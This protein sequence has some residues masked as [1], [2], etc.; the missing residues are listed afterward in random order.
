MCDDEAIK[1]GEFQALRQEITNRLTI[2]Y[3]ILALGLAAFGT[4]FSV[5]NR[6]S[7]VLAALSG[8]S[9]L[10]WLYWIDNSLSI[11]RIAA[12]I[13]VVLA[14]S[15]GTR[16]AD[17]LSWEM[18][19]RNVCVGGDRADLVLFK[20]SQANRTGRIRPA[21]SADWYATILF[22]GAPPVLLSLY[23]GAN[24]HH[25]SPPGLTVWA[26]AVVCA[27]IWAYAVRAF[28]RLVQERTVFR[29]A[30]LSSRPPSAHP[31]H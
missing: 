5:A 21:Q 19:F 15:L 4:G 10:L 9:A 20:N 16:D 8:I 12:Y 23:V 11:H 13:A 3:T 24:A 22:G 1:L 29:L 27:A 30:I 18:F 25:G 7:H 26:A 14:P 6:S 28:V 31:A 2:S 17:A